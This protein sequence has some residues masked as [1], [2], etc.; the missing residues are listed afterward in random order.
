MNADVYRGPW[1]GAHCRDSPVQVRWNMNTTTLKYTFVHWYVQ[2][3]PT[4][5]G[6]LY[7]N[8]SLLSVLAI[9]KFDWFSK[10]YCCVRM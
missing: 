9:Q 3:W 5:P 10:F 7:S 8:I 6:R 2:C 1:G 4:H